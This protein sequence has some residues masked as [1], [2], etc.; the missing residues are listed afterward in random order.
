MLETS[1]AFYNAIELGIIA[2]LK[3]KTRKL[4]CFIACIIHNFLPRR[5]QATKDHKVIKKDILELYFCIDSLQ[6]VDKLN[7]FEILCN[8]VPSR[9][10]GHELFRIVNE[11][12]NEIKKFNLS[13]IFIIF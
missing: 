6:L 3:G 8:L 11:E 5:R 10:C 1:I 7:I 13:N 9:L 12:K 2:G 4:A